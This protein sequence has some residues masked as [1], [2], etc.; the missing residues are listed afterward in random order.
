MIAAESTGEFANVSHRGE[1]KHAPHE[2]PLEWTKC[3][4]GGADEREPESVSAEELLGSAKNL[5]AC[6]FIIF[7]L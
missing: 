6:A 5:L 4:H 2:A 1:D 3:H 7:P